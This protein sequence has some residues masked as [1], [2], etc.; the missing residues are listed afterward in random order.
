MSSA[1]STKRPRSG[2]PGGVVVLALLVIV[3]LAV[4][5]LW[6]AYAKLVGYE[7][8]VALHMPP[9]ARLAV[10]VDLEQVVLFEPVRRHVF[11]VVSRE[12]TGSE[13]LREFEAATGIELSSELRE[14]MF[15]Q[16]ASGAGWFFAAGGLFPNEGVV[17]GLG[18]LLNQRGVTGCS[19]ERAR[20]SC[21]NQG[22]FAQQADDGVLMIASEPALIAAAERPNSEH[23]RLGLELDD[24]A[25]FG[26]DGSWLRQLGRLGSLPVVN[27]VV[28]G[29]E[30]LSQVQS[31]SGHVDLGTES[32]LTVT[33]RPTPDTD[34]HPLV[35]AV[36]NMLEGLS[37]L[38]A[39]T[40]HQDLAGERTML[41]TARV[42]PG[43]DG[44]V[45]IVSVWQ[46][47]DIDRAARSLAD[48]LTT[49]A[50][51]WQ[52]AGTAQ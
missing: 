43:P 4:S 39:L 51:T 47:Q 16:P 25:G 6:F 7:R 12:L 18:D 14:L 2:I 23:E 17:E 9:G 11:P 46:R 13:G 50:V 19:V 1:D 22:F 48:W 5:G 44:T 37:K 40:A 35:P 29:L 32:V 49:W 26:I 3:G 15:V 8:R 30:P 45:A 31:A 38:M 20:L 36:K 28:P 21:E 33:L 34:L 24:A 27:S 41:T 10:R 52:E 42:L